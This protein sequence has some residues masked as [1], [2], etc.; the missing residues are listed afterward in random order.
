MSE[1]LIPLGVIFLCIL[2]EGFFSGSEI[3]IVS[4]RWP[5]IRREAE[6]G[7]RRAALLVRL[8]SN[9]DRLLATTL[10]GTNISVIMASVTATYLAVNLI[11]LR[12]DWYSFMKGR[13]E[14]LVI[15]CLSPLTLFF[16]EIVPKSF[17]QS[18]ANKMAKNVAYPMALAWILLYPVTSILALFSGMI[19][20]LVRS[21]VDTSPFVTRE[22]LDMIVRLRDLKSDLKK[23][24]KR[25]IRR[26]FSFRETK[27]SEAMVPLIKVAA[28]E[29]NTSMQNALK[30]FHRMKYTR[31][32]VFRK[33][34]FNVVGILN[35]L[36]CLEEVNLQK[37]VKRVMESPYFVPETKGVV[38]LLREMEREN[39]HMA[40]AVDEYGGATGIITIEDI[41]EEIVGELEDEHDIIKRGLLRRDASNW[42]IDAHLDIEYVS[43]KLGLS[44]P[45][46]DYET[47][48]GLMIKHLGRIP[49]KGEVVRA[50]NLDLKA[51]AVKARTVE[52]IQIT[53]L[54]EKGK[55]D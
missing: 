40:V 23:H 52:K 17:F 4:C 7:D 45:R 43:E 54:A 2:T 25:M 3:A 53:I 12:G 5:R 44:V 28:Y 10:V 26:L 18:V 39:I 15:V 50:G 9:P 11:S 22:E 42:E 37:R 13:E 20:R 51:I 32:P 34:I 30:T 16:G 46:G 55:R 49:R 24:E 21:R 31:Y 29:E 48:A 19:G 8:W 41:L 14:L 6:G 1:L 36:C 47:F 33:K 35:I 38:D 27:V